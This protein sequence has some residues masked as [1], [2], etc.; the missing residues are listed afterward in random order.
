MQQILLREL[1]Y[2]FDKQFFWSDST[3][4]LKYLHNETKRF[5]RFVFNRVTFIRSHTNVESWKFVPGSQNPAD[6]MSNLWK[7]GPEFLWKQQCDWG[8]TKILEDIELDAPEV[9]K[10]VVAVATKREEN[11]LD[12]ILE[13][14]SSWFATKRRIACFLRLKYCLKSKSWLKGK[15]TVNELEKSEIAIFKFI[16]KNEFGDTISAILKGENLSKNNA[17][18]KLCPI[19]DSDEL[20]RV[21]GRISQA[22]TSY[23]VKHPIILPSFSHI[24]MLIARNAHYNVGH[25]GK[26]TTLASLRQNY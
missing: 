1:D 4:V 8:E 5:Q 20:L 11:S 25:L 14:S 26:E 17:L 23:N 16:Q 6:L 18:R 3:T 19:L 7:M 9:K 21:G 24:S 13:A 10:N 12:V 2:K 15:L 22:E